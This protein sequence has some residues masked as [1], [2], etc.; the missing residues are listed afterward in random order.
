MSDGVP[1]EGTLPWERPPWERP[2]LERIALERASMST[3]APQAHVEE[4]QRLDVDAQA[5]AEAAAEA[6]TE[7]AK[8][9]EE[10]RAE[11]AWWDSLGPSAAAVQAHVRGATA[12]RRVAEEQARRLEAEAAEAAERAAAAAAAVQ[13]YV[14]GKCARRSFAAQRVTLQA[15]GWRPRRRQAAPVKHDD[16]SRIQ[17]MADLRHG[18]P[19]DEPKQGFDE[20]LELVAK[21]ASDCACA[22][23]RASGLA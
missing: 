17:S 15:A 14:R 2:R 5:A 1:R 6:A 23:P 22:S 13:K 4:R 10:A 9:L 11:Q 7:L 8:A 12:R 20:L 19:R 16:A 21:F 3:G 18:E